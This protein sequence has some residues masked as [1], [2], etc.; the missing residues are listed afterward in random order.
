MDYTKA[1]EARRAERTYNS[2]KP[3][4]DKEISTS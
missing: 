3:L 1:I 2:D 4:T